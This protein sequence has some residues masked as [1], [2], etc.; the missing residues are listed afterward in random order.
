MRCGVP[1]LILQIWSDVFS[2]STIPHT[3][4]RFDVRKESAR[5]HKFMSVRIISRELRGCGD[6]AHSHECSTCR[7]CAIVSPQIST[8]QPNSPCSCAHVTSD[9]TANKQRFSC[10][11]DRKWKVSSQ[12]NQSSVRSSRPCFHTVVVVNF[13]LWWRPCW[14]FSCFYALRLPGIDF[15][16]TH[17]HTHTTVVFK[18]FRL[19]RCQKQFI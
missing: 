8:N 19:S 18:H 13:H 9:R 16:L 11:G 12:V 10:N 7:T 6:A 17:T 2:K 1:P 5:S 3:P 14:L 4:P 15:S